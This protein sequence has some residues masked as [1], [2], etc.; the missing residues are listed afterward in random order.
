MINATNET[1][2]KRDGKAKICLT[3]YK[4]EREYVEGDGDIRFT[5]LQ[6]AG[7]IVD[8]GMSMCG[9]GKN[10]AIFNFNDYYGNR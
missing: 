10:G 2:E 7:E 4:G 1:S 3:A 5:I 6:S 9:L 8:D